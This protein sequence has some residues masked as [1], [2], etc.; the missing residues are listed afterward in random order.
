MRGPDDKI[1][2]AG[3]CD[4][5]DTQTS[6]MYYARNVHVIQNPNLSGTA[7]SNLLINAYTTQRECGIGLPTCYY[8]TQTSNTCGPVLTAD[9]SVSNNNICINDCVNYSN[10]SLG[11]AVSYDWTFQGGSPSTFSGLTPP[12]VCYA[13]PGTYTTTLLIADCSGNTS[14]TNLSIIVSN[15]T[16]PIASFIPAQTSLCEGDCISFTDNSSGTNINSWNWTFAGGNPSTYNGQNP[17]TI[18]FNSAGTYNINLS[19][20]DDNGSDDTTIIITVN[21]CT[22]PTANFSVSNNNICEGDC[23]TITDLST[24]ASSWEWTFTGGNPASSS[25]QNPGSV[26]YETAGNYTIQLITTNTIGSDTLI[27]NIQ[28]NSNSAV[29]AGNDVTISL[30]DN[31]NLSATGFSGT[32]TWSPYLWLSC[33]MCPDPIATPEETTTYTVSVT[34]ANGCVATDNVTVYVD[35]KNIIFVPNIF[36]PNGDNHNDVLYV[37]GKGIASFNFYVFDRWGEKVFETSDLDS[38]WDG[39]V[40]GKPMHKAVFVYYLTVNFMDGSEIEQKGD[41]TLIR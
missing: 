41:I 8:P 36:S 29:N 6:T 3:G 9:A 35:S 5:Y 40:R 15:C 26:C 23:I 19:I 1:Y 22:L 21:A 14:T 31:T 38:G 37:R 20:T 39:T 24:G 30:G 28:V 11:P 4:Y 10:L 17:G 16:S 25:T 12:Q 32:Y 27:S 18:C 33:L 2:I 13:S 34:D 7:A